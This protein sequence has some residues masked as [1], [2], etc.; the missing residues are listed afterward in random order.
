MSIKN[1]AGI[2]SIPEA[3]SFFKHKTLSLI[4]SKEISVKLISSALKFL[5]L[6]YPKLFTFV[7]IFFLKHS[8]KEPLKVSK[9]LLISDWITPSLSLN[10]VIFD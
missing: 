6:K 7:F 3:L 1:S 5:S 9:I 8:S 10:A 4:S 2:S